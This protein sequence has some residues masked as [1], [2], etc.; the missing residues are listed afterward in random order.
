[1]CLNKNYFLV[2]TTHD[3]ARYIELYD[4]KTNHLVNTFQRQNLNQLTFLVDI[5]DS[6]AISNNDKLL[7]YKSK[8]QIKLYLIECGLELA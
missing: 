2:D 8:N 1:G 4:L 7:A 3:G 5:T 6:F